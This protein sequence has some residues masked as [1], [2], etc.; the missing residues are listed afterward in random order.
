MP[1]YPRVALL[2][3]M[4]CEPWSWRMYLWRLW[5]VVVMACPVHTAMADTNTTANYAYSNYLGSGYYLVENQE[6]AVIN[7]PITKKRHTEEGYASRWRLPVSVGSYS[8]KFDADEVGDTELPSDVATLTFVPGIEW[9]VPRSDRWHLEPYVDLGVG[10]N[11]NTHEEVLI[12]SVG[13]SSFY[14]LLEGR[15]HEWVNR[16]LYAG[17]YSFTTKGVNDFASFQTGV[18]WY[19]LDGLRWRQRRNFLTTYAM[20]FWHFNSVQLTSAEFNAVKL[21]NNFEVGLSWG[22]EETPADHWYTITR[23]GLGYRF[24]DGLESW[25]LFISRPL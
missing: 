4:T 19:L 7:F 12:Y 5:V 24:G 25:R 22:A 13:I 23:F 2:R 8:F 6:V 3:R 20:T 17:D 10:T 1:P 16:I 14:T 21:R 9:I 11:F 18:E 15:P